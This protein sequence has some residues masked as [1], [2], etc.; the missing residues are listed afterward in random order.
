MTTI[1]TTTDLIGNKKAQME[2]LNKFS[3]LS[4]EF[5]LRDWNGF[6]KKFL[7]EQD[8]FVEMD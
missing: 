2:L 5:L 1:T 8:T 6:E 3:H 7:K 4:T